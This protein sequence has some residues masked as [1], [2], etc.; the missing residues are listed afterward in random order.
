MESLIVRASFRV[1]SNSQCSQTISLGPIGQEEETPHAP[2]I[3]SV[4][5]EMLSLWLPVPRY[6]CF[7]KIPYSIITSTLFCVQARPS[8]VAA[9]LSSRARSGI[10][11]TQRRTRDSCVSSLAEY[12]P[13][14]GRRIECVPDASK[15]YLTSAADRYHV[16]GGFLR[17]HPQ[18]QTPDVSAAMDSGVGGV[19]APLRGADS[20]SIGIGK[21][22]TECVESLAF[23]A[24]RGAL[25]SRSTALLA[26]EGLENSRAGGWRP[27]RIVGWRQCRQGVFHFRDHPR[28]S[29][30]HRGRG[31]VLAGKPAAGNT[32]RQTAWG[33]LRFLGS[34]VD[35]TPYPGRDAGT[36]GRR[37]ERGCGCSV[38]VRVHAYGHGALRRREAPHRTQHAGAFESRSGDLQL[39]GRRDSAHA[40][41]G[42]GPRAGRCATAG[43]RALSAPR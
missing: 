18:D 35:R 26:A 40:V 22:A 2:C 13:Q 4:T 24:L 11:R 10:V 29:A 33:F 38:R 19:C 8:C 37:H 32:S 43:R 17:V 6:A 20:R 21:P 36:P 42:P 34:S 14:C 16:G 39:C 12:R 3:E 41:A 7:L 27:P 23:R 9:R 31:G 25:F 5:S 28:F 1:N 15:F 30:V